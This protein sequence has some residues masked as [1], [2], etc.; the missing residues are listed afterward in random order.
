MH[1]TDTYYENTKKNFVYNVF[2][3]AF[4]IIYLKMHLLDMCYFLI[5]G[6]IYIYIYICII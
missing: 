3:C 5:F 2:F 4:I 1:F 6:H